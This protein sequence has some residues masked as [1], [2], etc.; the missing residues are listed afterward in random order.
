M[1][2]KEGLED[3]KE[4][5]PEGWEGRRAWRMGRKEGLEDG[6]VPIV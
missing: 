1:G 4:G 2:R 5:G 3:E 6:K